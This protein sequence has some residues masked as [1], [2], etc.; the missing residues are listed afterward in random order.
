MPLLRITAISEKIADPKLLEQAA[1]I[2]TKVSTHTAVFPTPTPTMTVLGD[3]IE[4]Y[5][6]AVS[7]ALQGSRVQAAQKNQA[8]QTVF[9]LLQQLSHYVLMTA[10]GDRMVALESGFNI[11]KE[12]VPR[13]ITQPKNLKAEYTSQSGEMLVSVDRVKGA[14][15]YLHQYSTDPT[16]KE[17]SWMTM[18][19]TS[20]KCKL[21]GLTPGT[22]Y[23]LRVGVVGTK[24]QI[25]Y[26]VVISKLAV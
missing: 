5:R 4:A 11:S 23:F 7:D 25:L 13:V 9:N 3:A 2:H 10:N 15:A 18:N 20:A 16:L 21:Q 12:P 14:A 24:D 26:S 17:E 8:R 1:S 6:L 22:L 19:C